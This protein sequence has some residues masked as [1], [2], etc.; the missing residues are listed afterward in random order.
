MKKRAHSVR[1]FLTYLRHCV[2][3]FGK[4]GLFVGS[5]VLFDNAFGYRAVDYGAGM[6]VKCGCGFLVAAFDG[7]EQLFNFRFHLGLDSLISLRLLI[8]NEHALFCG[9]YI[10]HQ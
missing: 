3:F 4:A 7:F 6:G 1:N 2:E 5:R 9:L 8:N 10:R